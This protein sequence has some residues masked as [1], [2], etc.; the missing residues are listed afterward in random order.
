MWHR[1]VAAALVVLA[2]SL[3]AFA[4][5]RGVYSEATPPDKLALERLNLKVEW[6]AN[7]PVEGRRDSLTQIQLIDDQIFVQTRTGLVIAGDAVTGQLQWFAQ[8]GNGDF[9]NTYPVAANSQFVYV[10][11]VTKL[12]CFHRYTGVVEYVTELNTPPTTGPA[13]DETGVYCVL[14][15]RTGNSGSHRVAVYDVLR[16]IA[17][18]Q[19][20]QGKGPADPNKPA[21]KDPKAVNPVDKLITRYAPENMYRT[22]LPDIFDPSKAAKRGLEAPTGGVTG[23]RTPS[24]TTLSRVTPP[25]TLDSESPTPSVGLLPSLRQP[26]RLRNDFQQDIQRTASLGVIPPSLA[27]SLALGDLRPKQVGPPQRWEFG[28][29]SRVLFPPVLTPTRVWVVTDTQMLVALN[30][31]DKKTEVTQKLADPISATPGRAGLN[32]YVPLGSGYLVAVEGSS[33]NLTGGANV[34]WRAPVG[35]IANR[36]PF[37]TEKFVYSHGDNSG[38]VCV[39]RKLGEIIWRSDESADHIIGANEEFLYVRDRQGRFLVY[40]AKRPT[41][42]ATKHSAPLAGIDLAQFNIN[43][44]NRASDRIYLAADNGL[45]VC[46][47][48]MSQKYARPVR[49]CPEPT[50]NAEPKGGVEGAPGKEPKKDPEVMMKN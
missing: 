38:V 8:L 4:Q 32:H 34:L 48:D 37:V 43:V 1:S 21:P 12:H 50:V 31:R 16:P 23:S 20:V 27:A 10:A 29:T 26:Y 36:T 41:N 3:P 49:V 33:G 39:D 14:G 45:V 25:Y 11:H 44:T 2:S 30:K 46:L 7:I 19:P 6:T 47:R 17:I 15:L 5:V 13:A 35:G 24:L 9:A 42:A 40:D 28:L 22:N 18:S